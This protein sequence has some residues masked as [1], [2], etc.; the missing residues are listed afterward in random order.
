MTRI[1]PLFLL[2]LMMVSSTSAWAASSYD[3]ALAK[4]NAL[5]QEQRWAEA[6]AAAQQATRID[7]RRFE[8]HY[9]AAFVL[10]HLGQ[11]DDGMEWAKRALARA[12]GADRSRV[13]QLIQGI[14][15]RRGYAAAKREADRAL[16]EG[17]FAVAAEAYAE[18]WRSQPSDWELA[19]KA[20][21]LWTAKAVDLAKAAAILRDVEEWGGNGE[22]VAQ[23]GEWLGALHPQLTAEYRAELEPL[24]RGHHVE[25]P[26]ALLERAIQ[27]QPEQADAHRLLVEH[28]AA[29]QDVRALEQA[30][31]RAVL[32]A[33]L[34]PAELLLDDNVIPM[35]AD[36]AFSEFVRQSFGE[37]V[38]GQVRARYDVYAEKERRS[39]EA[40]DAA[41]RERLAKEAAA[42]AKREAAL[43]YQKAWDDDLE[44]AKQEPKATL[45]LLA[46]PPG[47]SLELVRLHPSDG[48]REGA[49]QLF[50]PDEAP[51]VSVPRGRYAY[52]VH[53]PRHEGSAGTVTLRAGAVEDLR[54]AL[55]RFS[56][57]RLQA[58]LA[59]EYA[60]VA[61][62]VPSLPK[63]KALALLDAF[64]R[65]YG[66]LS[67]EDRVRAAEAAR[68]AIARDEHP[69]FDDIDR[70]GVFADACPREA[71]DHDGDEDHDGCPETRFGEHLGNA[72]SGCASI[73][74]GI[75][76]GCGD[77]IGTGWRASTGVVGEPGFNSD[78]ST[79]VVGMTVFG[80]AGLWPDLELKRPFA[81]DFDA[82]MIG[83]Y[84]QAGFLE[85][86]L[87]TAIRDE[88][89]VY[90]LGYAGLLPFSWPRQ[91]KNEMGLSLLQPTVGLIGRY[92]F[93]S[94]GNGSYALGAYAGNVFDV[95]GLLLI[96]VTYSVH[97]L[98]RAAPAHAVQGELILNFL[99]L[100]Q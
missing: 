15:K 21:D 71:E 67:G 96:R 51:S 23:A 28:Y 95:F 38:W 87:G 1:L 52:R 69:V 17:R 97:F 24:Q 89:Q 85:A 22:A 27:L 19:L 74:A 43:A 40:R 82:F 46:E 20:A 47:A 32:L 81:P 30:L 39:Q 100:Y 36:A 13:E 73:P 16:A 11:F 53:L 10:T 7:D 45:R 8:G 57:E 70:D 12:K 80:S 91:E 55:E 84:F 50:A 54:L 65:D 25:D 5:A 94:D 93:G 59:D 77:A 62:S 34:S 18:A 66:R 61:K 78:F 29:T 92:G 90:G 75:C 58:M 26:P 64:L 14:E 83:T 37:L 72:W 9:L 76:G 3:R 86:G 88:L 60:V 56:D 41:E 98:G 63:E 44:A 35:M 99:Q 31:R 4:A 79:P 6:L 49:P 2:L 68:A 48:R 42:R 33:S